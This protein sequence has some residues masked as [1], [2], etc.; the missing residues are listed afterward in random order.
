MAVNKD[1]WKGHVCVCICVCVRVC[2]CVCACVRACVRVCV[3]V[4]VF[5][6]EVA[7]NAINPTSIIPLKEGGGGVY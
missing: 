6:V 1:R 3:R 5:C 7:V 2:V 4:S